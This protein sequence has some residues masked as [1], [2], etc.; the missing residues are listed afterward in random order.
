MRI[1]KDGSQAA[2]SDA[3]GACSGGEIGEGKGGGFFE[4]VVQGVAIEFAHKSLFGA[5]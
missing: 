2:T 4:A 3:R 5:R 1:K